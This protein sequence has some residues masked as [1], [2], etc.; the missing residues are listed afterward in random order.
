MKIGR[1]ALR[2]FRRMDKNIA[3]KLHAALQGYEDTGRGDVTKLQDRDGYR[4]RLGNYRVIFDL[5]NGEVIVL[6]V[7]PRGDMYKKRRV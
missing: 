4:L 7:G 1:T 3:K 5:T 6:E 2:Q